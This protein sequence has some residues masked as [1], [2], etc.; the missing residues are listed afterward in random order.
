MPH[1]TPTG[2][3]RLRRYVFFSLAAW[4][5]VALG[6]APQSRRAEA[7][8]AAPAE[9]AP[10][11]A[12][13]RVEPAPRRRR[14][15][16]APRRLAMS[17]TV[18]VLFFAGA[19]LSAVAGDRAVS[20]LG[21]EGDA[22]AVAAADALEATPA[23]T[24]AEPVE[25]E[26][27]AAEAPAE[28]EPVPAQ[29]EPVPAEP[30]PAP[31][32]AG[33]ENEDLLL[34]ASEG[35]EAAQARVESAAQ[36]SPAVDA[37]PEQAVA[38]EEPAVAPEP[39]TEAAHAHDVVAAPV[40]AATPAR[41]VRS[42]R[43][44]RA[45]RVAP[46]PAQKPVVTVPAPRTVELDPEVTTPGV[47]ATVWVHRTLPDPTPP[48]LR[49]ADD[50]AQRL[51]RL[52]RAAGADWSLV[53]GVLR[54]DTARAQAPARPATIAET[55]ER[56]V[57][58]GARR[59]A[60]NAALA[61]TGRTGA[62]D[63][64]L[65]LARYYRAIGVRGLVHGL[66]A[67]EDRLVHRLLADERVTVYGGGR[68]DLAAGRVDVRVVALLS[69]LAEAYG[70]VTV[71]SLVSGHRI[72]SRPGVVSAHVYG[73]AVDVAAL[74]GLSILGHQQPG[75]VTERAVRDIL[76]LPAEIRPRQLISLIGMG[77]PSFALAD[78]HDHIHV[79]F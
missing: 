27:V 2:S 68:E 39:A 40:P 70:Q 15:G 25:T 41:P 37:A 11:P 3:R 36:E 23:S 56:L 71:S 60:W 64:A 4:A 77:G 78:H 45:A 13:H 30:V 76:L 26:P 75:S 57:D 65:A 7:A 43:K 67:E 19:S 21:E 46:A 38:V 44:A 58:L 55:A 20:L 31:A 62:S 18:A 61:F 6:R 79:G 69:Y 24:E 9:L 35:A 66:R 12:P 29:P 63:R 1:S 74:G 51:V 22:A 17:F 54:A 32:P 72:Y 33:E 8:P 49:L 47:D 59:N 42:I 50:Y 48:S 28:P 16:P 5:L 34:P 53:L 52:S 73:A 10:A 14:R